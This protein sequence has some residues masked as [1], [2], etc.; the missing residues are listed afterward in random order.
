METRV[1][2]TLWPAMGRVISP[3]ISGTPISTLTSMPAFA[4]RLTD[5]KSTPA[6]VSMDRASP[7]T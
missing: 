7:E 4:G 5:R 6:S 2:G 3:V 1:K